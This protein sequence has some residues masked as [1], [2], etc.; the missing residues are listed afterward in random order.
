MRSAALTL[1]LLAVPRALGF[2]MPSTCGAGSSGNVTCYN[3]AL[4]QMADGTIVPGTNATLPVASYGANTACVV[5]SFHCTTQFAQVVAVA[6]AM[7]GALVQQA[8]PCTQQTI[9]LT[10]TIGAFPCV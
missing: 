3:G 9:N 2:V 4:F 5:W 10:A 6:T 1:L 7:S 8:L